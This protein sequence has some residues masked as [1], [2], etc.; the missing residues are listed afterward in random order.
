MSMNRKKK[1][2]LNIGLPGRDGTP[3]LPGP[4]GYGKYPYNIY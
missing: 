3:G 1:Y 4:K 2:F